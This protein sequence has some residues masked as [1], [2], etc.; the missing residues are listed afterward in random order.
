MPATGEPGKAATGD[1]IVL[2][3][4][5]APVVLSITIPLTHVPPSA[6]TFIVKL[7]LPQSP[8]SARPEKLSWK[9]NEAVAVPAYLDKE[10]L[11]S[12]AP[13]ANKID[14]PDTESTLPASVV[15]IPSLATASKLTLLTAAVGKVPQEGILPPTRI[16]PDVPLASL[17]PV[18]DVPP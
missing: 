5:I 10:A 17:V 4:V 11:I 7:S 14:A 16:W 13:L 8:N 9:T 15:P 18:P 12:P 3:T 2:S 6:D 1:I